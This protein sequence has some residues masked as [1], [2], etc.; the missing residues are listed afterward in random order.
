[1]QLW[2]RIK[3]RNVLHFLL[4]TKLCDFYCFFRNGNHLRKCIANDCATKYDWYLQQW[5][6]QIQKKCDDR[7]LP[8]LLWIQRLW[9]CFKPWWK[10]TRK[11][12]IRSYCQSNTGGMTILKWSDNLKSKVNKRSHAL[13][14]VILSY[15]FKFWYKELRQL[16]MSYLVRGRVKI[17][18]RQK[19]KELFLLFP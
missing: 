15:I 7:D 17:M 19:L 10:W 4:V 5:Q 3:K 9:C 1:M 6:L 8:R 13:I 12:F 18:L 14:Y 2:Q 16:H 11:Y